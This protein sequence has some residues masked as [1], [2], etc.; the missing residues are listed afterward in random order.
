MTVSYKGTEVLFQK[1]GN[2]WFIFAEINDEVVYSTMPDGMDPY[3]TKLELYEVIEDHMKRVSSM[4]KS[5]AEA[6]A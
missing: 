3:S 1:L 2:N 6:A 4:K 5:S